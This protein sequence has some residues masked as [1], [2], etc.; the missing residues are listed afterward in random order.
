MTVD[1][2][3]QISHSVSALLD[4]ADPIPGAYMLEISSPGID[5]PLVRTEDYDRFHHRFRSQDRARAAD[6][7]TQAFPRA[8]CSE[9]R[10]ANVRLATETGETE[11][12]LDAVGRA[13][14]VLTD[15]LIAGAATRR[16]GNITRRYPRPRP[17]SH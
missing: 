4:V 7:R 14:L 2:C 16:L 1:D 12:P 17:R 15:D 10:V 8:V 11:L 13:K 9:R 3:A 5:R 6:R